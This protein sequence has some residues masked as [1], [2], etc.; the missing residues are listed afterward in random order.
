MYTQ[1]TGAHASGA[2]T[3]NQPFTQPSDVCGR[4]LKS[5]LDGYTLYP[6]PIG[7]HAADARAD[8]LLVFFHAVKRFV[9][10]QNMKSSLR[11][12]AR[13][14]CRGTRCWCWTHARPLPFVFKTWARGY[15]AQA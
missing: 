1:Q 9:Q 10:V 2:G 11:R 15:L 4:H 13:S 3:G 12:H 14:W 6:I 8:T 5:I 7:T